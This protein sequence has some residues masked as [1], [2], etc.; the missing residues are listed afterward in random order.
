MEEKTSIVTLTQD[1]SRKEERG[2]EDDRGGEKAGHGGR[3]KAIQKGDIG[4]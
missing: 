2:G 3:G 4:K 1:A